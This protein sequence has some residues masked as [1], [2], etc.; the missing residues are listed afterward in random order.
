MGKGESSENRFREE[1]VMERSRGVEK[2][3]ETGR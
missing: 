3:G 1:G 2:M